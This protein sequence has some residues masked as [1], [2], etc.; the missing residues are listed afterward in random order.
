[1]SMPSGLSPR[2]T[3]SNGHVAARYQQ[4]ATA[5]GATLAPAPI[6]TPPFL[7]TA[8]SL[9]MMVISKLG[10]VFSIIKVGLFI[11]HDNMSRS[12]TAVQ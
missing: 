1:M 10:A 2:S 5:L 9:L 8:P 7:K 6:T 11:F 4:A 3:T 12:H